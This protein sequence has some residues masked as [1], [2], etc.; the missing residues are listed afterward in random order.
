MSGD[1]A[2]QPD[3][4]LMQRYDGDT[5]G[6]RNDE[7]SD[8]AMIFELAPISLWLQDLSEVKTL[9]A[10]W[11]KAGVTR[12]QDFLL[13]DP[14]RARACWEKSRVLKVNE[15]TLKLFEAGD[16]QHLVDNLGVIFRDDTFHAYVEELAQLWEGR[17][18]FF[19]QTVNAG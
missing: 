8:D 13:E 4:R 15:R 1:E 12:L 2:L 5:A 6:V 17:S 16:L 3:R 14:R 11:R 10:D 19:S 9:F 18:Q 7:S